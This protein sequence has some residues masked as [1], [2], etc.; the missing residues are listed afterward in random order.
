[1]TLVEQ[2]QTDAA[3]L[4][5]GDLR[6]HLRLGTGFSD[7]SIQN[8]VLERALA[9]AIGHVESLTG[10]ALLARQ[11]VST[12]GAWR[13]LGRHSLPRAPLVSFDGLTMIDAQGLRGKIA[14]DAVHVSRDTHRPALVAKGFVLPT[15]PTG[16][17]AEITF[18]A[19]FG[20]WEAVPADL[21]LG[22]LTLAAAYYEDRAAPGDLPAGV[23][24]L[25]APY[26]QMRLGASA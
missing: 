19:G 16:G 15:I 3:A 18:T 4:P 7:D 24:A 8:P 23:A 12:V 9:A 1:M 20:P 10:K 14:S 17:V 11:F 5:V 26:R 25:L 22:V 21:R 13:D 2:T 6:T